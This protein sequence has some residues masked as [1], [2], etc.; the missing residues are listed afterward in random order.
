[1]G[2]LDL[3]ANDDDDA[4]RWVRALWDI[5]SEIGKE[6]T[7]RSLYFTYGSYYEDESDAGVSS[8]NYFRKRFLQGVSAEDNND[9]HRQHIEL[10]MKRYRLDKSE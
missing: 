6:F 8:S 7:G 3:P 2:R 10:I 1:V 5:R 9:E 4:I